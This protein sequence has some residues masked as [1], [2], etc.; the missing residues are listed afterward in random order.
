MENGTQLFPI[1]IVMIIF[2]VLIVL[3]L[4]GVFICL[5]RFERDLRYNKKSQKIWPTSN[6]LFTNINRASIPA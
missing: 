6:P 3:I 4:V 2:C 5:I 1:Q